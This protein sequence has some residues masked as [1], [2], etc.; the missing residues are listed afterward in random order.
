MYEF[1][2]F[3]KKKRRKNTCV[4][5]NNVSQTKDRIIKFRCDDELFC[6]HEE[7]AKELGQSISKVARDISEDFFLDKELIEQKE[8][9]RH[10]LE[11][12]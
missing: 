8:N 1:Y 4:P 9:V 5:Q 10:F 12:A 11:N 7:L 2:P 6:K 3:W